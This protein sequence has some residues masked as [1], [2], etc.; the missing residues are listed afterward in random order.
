[1]SIKRTITTMFLVPILRVTKEDL[2]EN[3]F[4][5]A[6]IKDT[7]QE[8]YS[9]DVVYLLFKPENLDRFREFLTR[10]Y[11]RTETLIDDYDYED[12]YVVLV[13][14]IDESYKKDVILIKQGQYSKTS[15][16]FQKL[17]PVSEQVKKGTIVKV[18]PSLQIRIFKKSPDIRQ[19]WENKI[20]Q[21][22]DE[23]Q[24][25][26]EAYNEENEILTPKIIKNV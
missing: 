3:G 26:W 15:K 11:A 13:Y 23:A 18:E 4:L 16:E 12:G 10:E 8:E 14:K 21:G 19:Y 1:M 24:E 5:N 9:S 2:A 22:L 20:G 7:L 6:Y 25:V 17:F